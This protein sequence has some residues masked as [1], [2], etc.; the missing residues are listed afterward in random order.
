MPR[1][2]HSWVIFP[3]LILVA[4]VL[5]PGCASLGDGSVDYVE[6][7]VAVFHDELA[8]HGEW[9]EIEDWG[10]A[11]APHGVWVDWRPYTHGCWVDTRYGFTWHSYWDWGWITFHYGRWYE[12][13]SWGWLWIPD[14][15][16]GPAWVAWHDGPDCYGWAPLPPQCRWRS[17]H[18]IRAQ[19]EWRRHLPDHAWS[20]VA[21][22]HLDDEDLRPYI[23]PHARN[24]DLLRG[25]RDRTDYRYQDRRVVN[26]SLGHDEVERNLG[27]ALPRRELVWSDHEPRGEPGRPEPGR[28]EVYRPRAPEAVTKGRATVPT[29]ATRGDL[30]RPRSDVGA[31]QRELERRREVERNRL[32][33]LRRSDQEIRGRATEMEARSQRENEAQGRERQRQDRNLDAWRQREQTP[34]PRATRSR[35][36]RYQPNERSLPAPRTTPTPRSATTPARPGASGRNEGQ[37]RPSAPT[38]ATPTPPAVEPARR[39]A[40]VA[41]PTRRT[42][43]TRPERRR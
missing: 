32:E 22:D 5:V 31:I 27:H 26:L 15:V 3:I 36:P 6:V 19:D 39:P 20:F 29:S 43:P 28:V 9:L 25:G 17:Q 14:G 34:E 41:Q 1:I 4:A 2:H 18:G 30:D 11:W 10:R 8:L 38:R 24:G 42:E 40:S 37:P 21:R 7:D 13:P 35:T 12:H 16:W 23:Y 33:Q